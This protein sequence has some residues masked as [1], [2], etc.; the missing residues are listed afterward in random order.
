MSCWLRREQERA[1]F[2]KQLTD[3]NTEALHKAMPSAL[4]DIILDDPDAFFR[5]V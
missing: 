5:L 4:E 3:A 2:L 1:S